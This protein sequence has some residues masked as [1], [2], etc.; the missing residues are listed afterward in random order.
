MAAEND[1]GS[2]DWAPSAGR[3]SKV[4]GKLRRRNAELTEAV[5]ARDHFLSVAA[6]EL[7]NPMTPMLGHV[8]LL[9]KVARSADDEKLAQITRGLD[10]LDRLMRRYVKRATTLLDVSRITAGKFEL[11]L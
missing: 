6:H 9:L 1:K 3:E 2:P 8:Q 5:T 11:A 4:V 10:R 7:R